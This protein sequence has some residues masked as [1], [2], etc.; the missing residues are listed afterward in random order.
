MS[1]V[2]ESLK[3]QREEVQQ[4]LANLRRML[5]DLDTAISALEGR[6]PA[7]P[8]MRASAPMKLKDAIA[9]VLMGSPADYEEIVTRVNALDGMQTTK[10]SIQS[11]L[12][13]MKSYGEVVKTP[14]DDKWALP[15]HENGEAE[16]SPDTGQDIFS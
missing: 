9:H 12:S 13:R 11:T 4:K 1:T 8:T 10:S 14:N 2:L 6:P 7:A 15:T 3:A 5:R 16:A